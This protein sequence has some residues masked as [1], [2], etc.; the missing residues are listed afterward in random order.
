MFMT[1]VLF[2]HDWK[3]DR[4]MDGINCVFVLKSAR[5]IS[6]QCS[7]STRL[8]LLPAAWSLH[9]GPSSVLKILPFGPLP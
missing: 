4:V 7:A 8:V 1:L 9:D 2:M 6:G 3:F 5:D